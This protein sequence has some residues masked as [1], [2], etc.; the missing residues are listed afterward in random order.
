MDAAQASQGFPRSRSWYSAPTVVS[1]L[2]KLTKNGSRSLMN[3][4]TLLLEF[5]GENLAFVPHISLHRT[6]FWPLQ[7]VS[8]NI[9]NISHASGYP[10]NI[11]CNII[12]RQV[13]SIFSTFLF[14]SRV[15]LEANTTLQYSALLLTNKQYQK[16]RPAT[17]AYF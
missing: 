8:C 1:V 17:R 7:A 13:F 6:T 2:A 15:R 3:G 4:F 5:L 11:S 10:M 12:Q 14:C 16:I 9:A